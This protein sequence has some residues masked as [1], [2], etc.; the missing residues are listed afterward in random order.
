MNFKDKKYLRLENGAGQTKKEMNFFGYEV[1]LGGDQGNYE[2]ILSVNENKTMDIEFTNKTY[3][4]INNPE[5]GIKLS[6]QN[7]ILKTAKKEI[8]AFPYIGDDW[9]LIT[10]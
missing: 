1:S 2:L 8:K 3:E 10:K 5:T 7:E 6:E 9:Q 4:I